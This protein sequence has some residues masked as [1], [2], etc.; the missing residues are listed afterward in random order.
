[1]KGC[2]GMAIVFNTQAQACVSCPQNKECAKIVK[3]SLVCIHQQTNV[4]DFIES[5]QRSGMSIEITPSANDLPRQHKGKIKVKKGKV[6]SVSLEM[7]SSLPKGA[8]SIASK[9]LSIE[10]DLNQAV[11]DNVNPFKGVKPSYLSSVFDLVIE[12]SFSKENIVTRLQQLNPNWTIPTTRSYY[13]SITRAL[14]GLGLVEKNGKL[15]VSK[16]LQ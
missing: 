11:K 12:G 9:M 5:L 8:K 3:A 16:E 6:T 13:H 14:I 15:Y 10:A 1:M 2:Y 7:I 4:T